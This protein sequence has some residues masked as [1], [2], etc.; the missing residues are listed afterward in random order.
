MIRPRVS[1]GVP[2]YN[3]ERFLAETLDCPR[4]SIRVSAGATGRWKSIQVSGLVPERVVCALQPDTAG[5][6]ASG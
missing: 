4:S 3:G 6:G 2:V 1:I 5:G